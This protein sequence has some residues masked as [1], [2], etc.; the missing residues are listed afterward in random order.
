MLRVEL[1]EVRIEVQGLRPIGNGSEAGSR[2]QAS[3]TEPGASAAAPD[4]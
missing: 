1:K 2:A 3:S 4:R